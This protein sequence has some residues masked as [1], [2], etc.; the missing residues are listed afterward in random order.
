MIPKPNPTIQNHTRE[1]ND[2]KKYYK[3]VKFCKI[4]GRPFGVD[5][6]K[7]D[8]VCPVCDLRGR[9]SKASLKKYMVAVC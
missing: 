4:C 5:K 3:S 8:D 2:L 1:I 9:N 6:G 7:G